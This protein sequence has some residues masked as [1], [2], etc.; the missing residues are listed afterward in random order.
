MAGIDESRGAD[1]A[2]AQR[3]KRSDRWANAAL[4]L[5]SVL[6]S[7]LLIEVSFR[8]VFG[9]P[10]FKLEDWRMLRVAYNRLGQHA[11]FDPVLGWT[12]KPNYVSEVHNT[13]DHGI[14]RNG[15]ETEIRTRQVLAV[16]DSFTEGWEVADDD[17]WPAFLEL[18]SGTPIVNGGVGGYGTDQIILRAEQ[19]LPIVNP[20]TLIVGFLNFDLYR[21]GHKSFGAPK[22]WFTVEKGELVY[23]AP[24]PPEPK[25]EPTF[26]TRLSTTVRDGLAYFA[27]VDFIMARGAQ[28]FWYGNVSAEYLKIDTDPVQVTCL[29]LERLKKRTDEMKVRTIL[30]MQYYA[31]VILEGDAPP[32]DT[33]QVMA[34]AAK[35]GFEIV[36]QFASLK[37]LAMQDPEALREYYLY[38]D[39]LYRH[40]SAEGNEQAAAL[41]LKAL[42]KPPTSASR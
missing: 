30:F 20:H 5:V 40:M 14:R 19:L 32:E 27:V 38:D 34:C 23:H 33:R 18:M 4:V 24:A 21:T 41:L 37:G 6:A 36:D 10:V 1:F 15:Q 26:A 12:L 28:D 13:L 22:P 39:G 7:L 16:G 11:E 2:S 17:S 9:L 29:L 31:P 42:R 8:L 3:P 25:R 35:L